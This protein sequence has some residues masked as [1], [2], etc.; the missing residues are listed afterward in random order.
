MYAKDMRALDA[1]I[2]VCLVTIHRKHVLIPQLPSTLRFPP[3]RTQ[4]LHDWPHEFW[5]IQQPYL[6]Q[7]RSN[8]LTCLMSE[9]PPQA[10]GCPIL[11]HKFVLFYDYDL[12]TTQHAVGCR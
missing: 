2:S 5:L 4:S 8:P 12:T 3:L 6:Y 1:N 11:N 9:Q 10:S 7:I